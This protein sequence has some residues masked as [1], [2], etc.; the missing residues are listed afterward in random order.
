MYLSKKSF[1]MGFGIA[2]MIF[3]LI[4][5]A[6]TKSTTKKITEIREMTEEEIVEKAKEL[7]MI[8]IEDAATDDQEVNLAIAKIMDE[9]NLLN[10]K[11]NELQKESEKMEALITSLKKEAEKPK[12]APK[13]TYKTIYIPGGSSSEDVARILYKN[14]LVNSI[15]KFNK[16]I[17]DQG[18]A[19]Y[20]QSGSFKVPTNSTY[21]TVLNSI[22]K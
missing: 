15:D 2:L 5:M 18:K 17:V 20:L 16:Y 9:K 19:R 3:S 14:G 13:V 8:T 4:N 7:G 22:T 12:E 21:Y 1:L 6:Y 11:Y 10:E